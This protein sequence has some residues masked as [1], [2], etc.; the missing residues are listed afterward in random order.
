MH[1]VVGEVSRY[2]ILGCG[3]VGLG[4]GSGLIV[5]EYAWLRGCHR[6]NTAYLLSS[7]SRQ[8]WK[9]QCDKH[10][11]PRRDRPERYFVLCLLTLTTAY[12]RLSSRITLKLN[13]VWTQATHS[14]LGP[15]L[16]RVTSRLQQDQRPSKH[17]ILDSGRCPVTTALA[18]SFH[19]PARSTLPCLLPAAVY[20][21]PDCF[22][23]AGAFD[24]Q[25]G[26]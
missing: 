26:T 22:S 5:S 3:S 20:R 13:S 12:S 14:A 7:A 6:S 16:L 4:S 21:A 15:G 19:K 8:A 9:L 18:Q 10:H 24:L 25:A 2:S 17:F 23:G 11:A 1:T